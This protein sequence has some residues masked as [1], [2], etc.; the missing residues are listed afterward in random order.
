MNYIFEIWYE[1]NEQ[2]LQELY[3]NL[4]NISYEYGVNVI[5]SNKS[6]NYFLH[7]MYRNSTK[8]IIRVI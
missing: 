1:E 2:I 6:Y 4:I 8:E 5:S 3:N 7:M